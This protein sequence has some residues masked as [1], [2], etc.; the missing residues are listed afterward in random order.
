MHETFSAILT[1]F[2]F[3]ELIQVISS[4][5]HDAAFV[6]E[7]SDRDLFLRP[8]MEEGAG[9]VHLDLQPPLAVVVELL[10][11]GEAVKAD[12]ERGV[13]QCWRAARRGGAAAGTRGAHRGARDP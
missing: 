2:R 1:T 7:A 4:E 11:A 8:V 13:R 10:T 12:C 9:G 3:K 5:Q 6:D